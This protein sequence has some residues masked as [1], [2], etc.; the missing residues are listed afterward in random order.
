MSRGRHRRPTW[1]RVGPTRWVR[2]RVHVLP[3]LGTVLT[4]RR[5]LTITEAAWLRRWWQLYGS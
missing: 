5:A 1:A 2:V 3:G 4:V